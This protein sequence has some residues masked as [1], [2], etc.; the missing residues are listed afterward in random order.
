MGSLFRSAAAATTSVFLVL[1]R[2][3]RSVGSGSQAPPGPSGVVVR[4][5]Y[6]YPAYV[7][8]QILIVR[9]P[10]ECNVT[11]TLPFVIIITII[12]TT[13]RP[14][15]VL[16]WFRAASRLPSQ[17][18]P[19]SRYGMERDGGGGS[20]FFR[21][22]QNRSHEKMKLRTRKSTLYLSQQKRTG[23]GGDFLGENIYLVLF[24]IALRICNC[25]LVQ[26]SFVPDEYW[27]S[28]EV[29][30]HMVFKYPL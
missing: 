13:Q 5:N 12:I 8:Q 19:R 25:F 27:Q 29:A 9:S 15:T 16:L 7:V 3:V 21:G 26:T 22:L 17:S 23:R 11:P 6:P 1:R 18:R 4:L 10:K 20:L 14:L 24:T 2:A 30:H 28:L